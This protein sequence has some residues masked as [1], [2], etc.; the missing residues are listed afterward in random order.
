[1]PLPLCPPFGIVGPKRERIRP[2]DR[3]AGLRRAVGVP[4]RRRGGGARVS[5][6][7]A[8]SYRIPPSS[9]SSSAAAA[10]SS[11][12]DP[13]LSLPPFLFLSCHRSTRPLSCATLSATPLCVRPPGPAKNTEHHH[14]SPPAGARPPASRFAQAQNVCEPTSRRTARRR[15]REQGPSREG[16]FL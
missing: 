9:S 15:G 16:S 11:T 2:S 4:Q 13:H 1:L 6:R 8:V 12:V 7:G 3:R 10:A 14:P 5:P